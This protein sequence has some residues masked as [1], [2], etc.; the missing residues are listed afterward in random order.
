MSEARRPVLIVEDDPALQ[1]Q[2]K[3][4][5]DAYEVAVASDRE[6]AIAQLRHIEPAV[7]TLD[8]G[9]PPDSDGVSEGFKTLGQILELA[10]DTKVIVLTGQNDVANARRAVSEG[11]YDFFA[12]PFEPDVLSLIIDR[13]FRI[14][15]LQVE[16]RRLL[17]AQAGAIGGIITGAPEMLEICRM[18]EKVASTDATVLLLGES[19]RARNSW[20]VRCTTLPHAASNASS[21]STAPPSPTHCWKANSSATSEGRLPVPPS[22]PSDASKRPTRARC[23][24]MRSAICPRHCRPNCC[25]SCRSDRSSDWAEEG[26]YRLMCASFAPRIRTCRRGSRREPFARTC[27]IVWPKS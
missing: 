3:W 19:A 25:V 18:V 27:F 8:L 9:L 6:E 16:N 11:A 21:R 4:A 24:S 22:R 10:P 20:R 26:R 14:H 2:M 13:A 1:V 5:F 7:V 12:K 23:S 15:E 17:A